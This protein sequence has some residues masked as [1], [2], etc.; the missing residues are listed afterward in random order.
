MRSKWVK[1]FVLIAIIAYIVGSLVLIDRTDDDV[2][3]KI[4][5][6]IKDSTDSHFVS[7]KDVADFLK[8][9]GLNPIGV[10]LSEINTERIEK[11][12]SEMALVK[13]AECYVTPSGEMKVDVYQREPVLRVLSNNESF[14]VDC[15]GEIMP[16]SEN[17]TAYVIVVTGNVSRKFAKTKVFDF[18]NF[19]RKDKFWNAQIEQINVSSNEEVSL[20]PRVGDHVILFGKLEDY[21]KK[22]ARLMKVYKKGFG[23][24]GWNA[25]S[26]INLKYE[27]QVVCTKK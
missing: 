12:M 24:E 26:K 22:L 16:V 13:R 17:F 5:V 6:R 7:E 3:R 4:G 10:R 20:V 18:V 19:L 9:K 8:Q 27:G 21:D 25:Y 11:K 15:E 14:Y 23:A 2:C 1:I